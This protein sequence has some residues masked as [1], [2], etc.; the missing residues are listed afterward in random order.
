METPVKAPYAGRVR[1]ILATVN[2]QVDAGGALLRIDKIEEEGAVSTAPTV[3]F[4]AGAGTEAGDLRARAFADL[5]ALRALIMGYDVSA[6]RGAGPA[7]RLRPGAR[8]DCRSTTPS[9]CGASLDVLATFADSASCPGTGRPGRRSPGTSGCT[10][11]GSTSTPTCSRWTW[12]GR[13]CRRR[14][15]TRLARGAGALRGHRSGAETGAGGSGVPRLPGP[16]SGRRPDPDRSPGCWSGGATPCRR[17]HARTSRQAVGEVVER[18]VVAT[19][20]RYPVIG[21][22]ARSIR[23]EAYERPVI[24]AAR[25]KLYAEVRADAGRA[26]GRTRTRRTG[27]GADRRA[28]RQPGAADPV[29][30]RAVARTGPRACRRCSRR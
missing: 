9:C 5:A 4:A 6:G 16:G 15:R 20:L 8:A 2:S 23:Y 19:R 13:V 27:R 26:G 22:L 14:F 24:E 12:S 21:D 30:G 10:A 3:E 25:T 7:R 17:V 1:E 29:A 18:L 28:G 11:P